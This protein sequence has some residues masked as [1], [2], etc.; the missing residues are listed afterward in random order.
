MPIKHFKFYIYVVMLFHPVF[1]R[2]KKVVSEI[3]KEFSL[4]RKMK[5]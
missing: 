4:D 1:Q 3:L 2:G 5:L